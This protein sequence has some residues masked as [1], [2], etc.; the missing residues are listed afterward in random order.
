MICQI[1]YTLYAGFTHVCACVGTS[2]HSHNNPQYN[3]FANMCWLYLTI[4]HFQVP[5]KQAKKLTLERKYFTWI[6]TT[7]RSL[8]I[9]NNSELGAD[10]AIVNW[11]SCLSIGIWMWIM[12]W[13]RLLSELPHLS[14]A[15]DLSCLPWSLSSYLTHHWIIHSINFFC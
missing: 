10:V 5:T 7:L 11:L 13:H 6:C 3:C 1:L 9:Y 2:S 14:W 4:L 8:E 15:Y 12:K